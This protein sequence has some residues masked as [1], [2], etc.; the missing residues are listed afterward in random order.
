MMRWDMLGERTWALRIREWVEE[1]YADLRLGDTAIRARRLYRKGAS[2]P[3]VTVNG[4]HPQLGHHV[5][6]TA[7]NLG[8]ADAEIYYIMA[9]PYVYDR[10]P[11]EY[12][13]VGKNPLSV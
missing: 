3:S 12:A 10:D 5:C 6:E 11:P 7:V 9:R 8:A 1:V 2:T 4:Q 13:G